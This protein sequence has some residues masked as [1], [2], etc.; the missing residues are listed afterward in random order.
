M[1]KL[2]RSDTAVVLVAAPVIVLA[3]SWLAVLAWALVDGHPIWTVRARNLAEAAAFR[4]GA[5]VVRRMSAGESAGV[6]AEVRPGFIS[7]SDAV[8]VT[9]LEAAA[10]ARRI[11]IVRLLI[12]LEG[13]VDPGVWTKAWC[14]ADEEGIRAVLLAHRPAAATTECS[15]TEER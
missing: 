9:P 10:K 13:D 5:E 11:E 8:T 15:P 12:D 14:I 6:A 1:G 7:G 4:D 2:T 3:V